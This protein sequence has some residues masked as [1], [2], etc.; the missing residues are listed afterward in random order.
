MSMRRLF[1]GGPLDGQVRDVQ[2]LAGRNVKLRESIRCPGERPGDVVLYHARRIG[3]QSD[4]GVI[5]IIVMSTSMIDSL[6]RSVLAHVTRLAG[7]D[8]TWHHDPEDPGAGE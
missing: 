8:V 1:V 6:G 3:W 4:E 5:S 2:D 7:L